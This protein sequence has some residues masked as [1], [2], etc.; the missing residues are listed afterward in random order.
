M[1]AAQANGISVYYETQGEPS[2]RPVLLLMG[3]GAQLIRWPQ[4][5]RRTLVER[6][7]RLVLPDNRDVGLSS[8]LDAAGMPDFSALAKKGAGALSAPYTLSHMAADMAALLDF[9]G[10]EKALVAGISMGGMIAQTMAIE[11][12]EKVAGICIIASTSGAPDLPPPAPEALAGL[13]SVPPAD[14]EGNVRHMV[15]VYT[16]FAGGSEDFDPECERKKSEQSFDRDFYPPGVA[17]QVA[18]ILASG[19]RRE[20][21]RRVSV[22]CAVVHGDC[23]TLLPPAHGR[24]VAESVPGASFRLIPGLGHGLCY[25]ALIGEIADEIA[26]LKDIAAW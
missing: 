10:I 19:S 4:E 8:H 6:G 20:K 15:G 11:H 26:R 5:L 1:P 7:M 25:P 16:T 14:R 22:P 21:L 12:P 9:L 24:D 18:A 2:G 3:L 13:W 17:R 23:D